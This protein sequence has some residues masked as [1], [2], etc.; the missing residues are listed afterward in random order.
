M[1]STVDVFSEYLCS[2]YSIRDKVNQ[3]IWLHNSS[4]RIK[5][6]NN[7]LKDKNNAKCLSSDILARVEPNVPA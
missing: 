7:F 6:K 2:V 4:R 5:G 3:I 1:L